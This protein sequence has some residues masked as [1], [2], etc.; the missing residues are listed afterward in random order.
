M[1]GRP[2]RK[3]IYETNYC[4]IRQSNS[5]CYKGIFYISIIPEHMSTAVIFTEEYS[6]LTSIYKIYISRITTDQQAVKPS[7]YE[8]CHDIS[9]CK[10]AGLWF[11]IVDIITL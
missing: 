1:H 10:S 5:R 8:T 3:V 6:F 9:R 2:V 4:S 7:I 11:A